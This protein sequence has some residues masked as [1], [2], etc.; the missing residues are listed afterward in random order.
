LE[1]ESFI[2]RITR[3]LQDAE[4]TDLILDMGCQAAK[5]L[6]QKSK[7]ETMNSHVNRFE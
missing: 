5:G 3:L 1:L 4:Q 2:S 7:P 6:T